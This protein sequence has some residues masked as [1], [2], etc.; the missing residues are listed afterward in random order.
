MKKSMSADLYIEAILRPRKE[1]YQPLIAEAVRRR[2]LLPKASKERE[3]VQQE[4]EKYLGL[5]YS[6]GHFRDSY[7]ATSA[8]AHLGLSWWRDVAP[9]CTE[10]QVLKGDNLKR[11]RKMV[12]SA[13]WRLPTKQELRA[14][15]VSVNNTGENSLEGW[16][17]Y[18]VET[19]S[20]L[21]AFLDQAIQLNSSIICSL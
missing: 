6:E 14:E 3:N 18:F 4:V 15:R 1:K 5:I 8:L 11:F 20:R 12:T 19:R 13:E 16:H 2:D 17:Q 10:E 21:L 9:L 7:N